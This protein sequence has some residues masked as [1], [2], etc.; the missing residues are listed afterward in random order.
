MLNFKCRSKVNF[1]TVKKPKKK[2]SKKKTI[3]ERDAWSAYDAIREISLSCDCGC[4]GVLQKCR[5]ANLIKRHKALRDYLFHR[6]LKYAKKISILQSSKIPSFSLMDN[7]DV[8]SATSVGLLQ[9]IDRFDINEGASFTTFAYRRIVGEVIDDLRRLSN[10]T[11]EI[12]RRR[13]ELIPKIQVLTHALG[14]FPTLED[15]NEHFSVTEFEKCLDPRMFV[16][17]FN[18]LEQTE[19][20]DDSCMELFCTTVSDVRRG[21]SGIRAKV[22]QIDLNSVIRD[23][24]QIDV[25]YYYYY[26]GLP[27]EEISMIESRSVSYMSRIK[28]N[29]EDILRNHYGSRAAM[30]DA[31]Y[32]S[33][34]KKDSDNCGRARISFKAGDCN[35]VQK[36]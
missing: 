29:A 23:S 6:Y 10:F 9:A 31:I 35:E 7:A 8:S 34:S 14:K 26:M 28:N 13:R 2:K 36:V 16:N 33:A 1:N 5:N 20:N 27:L 30:K 11:T 24:L 3:Q 21:S 25:L 15:I 4:L 19:E 12:S 22:N 32:D 17:V 18:Q